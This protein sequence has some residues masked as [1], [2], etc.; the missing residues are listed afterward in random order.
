MGKV[1]EMRADAVNALFCYGRAMPQL[2]S[3]C[4]KHK[5]VVHFISKYKDFQA[6]YCLRNDEIRAN[7]VAERIFLGR[8]GKLKVED[9]R[10]AIRTAETVR[11]CL[12]FVDRFDHIYAQYL[13]LLYSFFVNST[14][15]CRT[16]RKC[17]RDQEAHTNV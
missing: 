3:G 14:C 11:E 9:K 4:E 6:K 8:Q 7:Y 2:K 1:Y 13:G 15:C 17:R 12:A 16:H 10:T 5:F